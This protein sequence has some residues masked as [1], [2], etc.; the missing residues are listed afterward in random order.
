MAEG[1]VNHY[2]VDDWQAYSAGT[3]PS[4]Y[5]HELAVAAMAEIGVDISRQ[6]SKSVEV[7]RDADFDLVITVCDDAS[8]NCPVWLG[9]GRRMHVGF[10]D[11]AKATGT[12]DE[13]LAVFRCVRDEMRRSLLKAL[14]NGVVL[15]SSL[16]I[17]DPLVPSSTVEGGGDG[18][19]GRSG[20]SA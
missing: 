6:R 17:P 1:M 10:E 11:P 16:C 12:K 3:E 5:V 19:E 15:S 9:R 18:D 2:L 14:A 20:F 8:E 7:F 13:R 4:G